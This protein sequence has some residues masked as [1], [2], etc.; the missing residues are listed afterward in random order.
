MSLHN[1]RFAVSKETN[2]LLRSSSKA[3][4]VLWLA[5]SRWLL[6]LGFCRKDWHIFKIYHCRGLWL[7]GLKSREQGRGSVWNCCLNL[8]LLYRANDMTS[9]HL[10]QDCF[11][12]HHHITR[13][14]LLCELAESTSSFSPRDGKSYSMCRKRVHVCSA[15]ILGRC[16]KL[17]SSKVFCTDAKRNGLFSYLRKLLE[18]HERGPHFYKDFYPLLKPTE[19]EYCKYLKLSK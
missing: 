15:I 5:I 18:Y 2:V 9:L 7:H 8:N 13:S 12:Q 6:A 3:L 1:P 19:N 17:F 11:C 16:S 4:L 10:P 14:F